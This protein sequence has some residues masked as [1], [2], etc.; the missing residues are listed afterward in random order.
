MLSIE[1]QELTETEKQAIQDEVKR[2]LESPEG[3][4][5]WDNPYDSGARFCYWEQCLRERCLQGLF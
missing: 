4:E 5:L 3:L 1:T 2:G